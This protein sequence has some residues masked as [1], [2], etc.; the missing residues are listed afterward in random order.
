MIHRRRIF[1]ALFLIAVGVFFILRNT[2]MIHGRTLEL[3]VSVALIVWGI[4]KLAGRVD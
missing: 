3:V 1:P 4:S 2:G